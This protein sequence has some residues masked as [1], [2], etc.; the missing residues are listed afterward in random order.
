MTNGAIGRG[1]GTGARIHELDVLRGAALLGVFVVH[2]AG[3]AFYKLPIGDSQRE[4]F[5]A[6]LHHRAALFV[7]DFLFQ[8]KANTLFATLFGMGFW[9]MLERLTERQANF[10]AVYGRRLGMLLLIG[11]ANWFLFFPGDVLHEY[12]LVGFALLALRR[13]SARTMLG[14]G[15]VL[16][17]FASPVVGRVRTMIGASS[18]SFNAIQEQ[19]FA[20]DDYWTW[21]QMLAPTMV[22]RDFLH[23]G[24]LGWFL[25]I[26]GRFLI[27]AWVMRERWIERARDHLTTLRRLVWI[28]LP[29]GAAA[30]LW[31]LLIF[32]GVLPGGELLDGVL[33]A[34][35][36][37]LM[38]LGYALLL[39]R[40]CQSPTWRRVALWFAPV[41]R[42]ALTAY[43]LHGMVFTFVAMQFGLG[44]LGLAGPAAGLALAIALYA[45]MTLMAQQWL[46]RFRYGP[47]EYLWRW[48][49]YG[50][51]PVFRK[52]AATESPAT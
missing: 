12:A 45:L 46:A 39:L 15:L 25:Y 29:V 5:E 21:V 23:A 18:D 42:V 10:A 43:V 31:S 26:L 1:A 30:E 32:K 52:A 6:Q 13:W 50:R 11:L 49:T 44:W 20:V 14:V 2:F 28:V 51:R 8:N 7:S 19:A 36:A 17:L 3:V 24:A 47:L 35:G 48:A 38:A 4:L 33:H 37:P 22:Q 9:I 34:I 41:G 16:A 40:L 27:G